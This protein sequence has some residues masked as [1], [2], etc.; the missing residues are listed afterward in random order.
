MIKKIILIVVTYFIACTFSA[1]CIKLDHTLSYTQETAPS[2]VNDMMNIVTNFLN[3]EL[4]GVLRVDM[5]YSGDH[6]HGMVGNQTIKTDVKRRI[7]NSYEVGCY[8]ITFE[9]L[10]IDECTYQGH[11][12]HLRHNCVPPANCRNTFGSYECDCPPNFFGMDKSGEITEAMY[13]TATGGLTTTQIVK[14]GRCGGH[15][16]TETCCREE[17]LH[18]GKVSCSRKCKGD[19]KCINDPCITLHCGENAVCK[20]LGGSKATCEC[21][22]GYYGDPFVACQ[23]SQKINYCNIANCPCDCYCKH[24]EQLGG[25]V[26]L[27]KNGY[28][29]VDNSILGKPVPHDHISKGGKRLDSTTCLDTSLPELYLN[30]PNPYIL[31]QGDTYQEYGIT[32]VDKNNEDFPR[33]IDFEYSKPFGEYMTEIGREQVTYTLKTPWLP[34]PE[35]TII[36]DVIVIDVD[37]CTYTGPIDQ[38]RHKC[39]PDIANCINTEGSYSC[40]CKP[41]YI[42]DGYINGSGCLDSVPPVITCVGQ[43]CEPLRFQVCDS[44]GLLSSTGR[45]L[46]LDDSLSYNFIDAEL[47]KTG[48]FCLPHEYPCFHAFDETAYGTVDLTSR[49][50]QGPF[51]LFSQDSNIWIF[52]VPFNVIDD[53]GNYAEPVFR[54]IE[55][56]KVDIELGK[57]WV[58]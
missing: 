43:G 25:Y 41:G 14:G 16:S 49:I 24:E 22:P 31:R 5:N 38:F 7:G 48:N 45:V 34:E 1:P 50:Q 57:Q 53:D 56:I 4:R 2:D 28:I 37:E 11:V 42:G 54:Y 3:R 26:C 58:S 29:S 10:D 32:V 20:R 33:Q 55:V 51:E 18:C 39:V 27:P 15:S 47:R 8:E 44:K 17:D 52:R 23:L 9:I 35:F 21:Q 19:F 40:R 30:P 12:Q 13:V 6:I 46:V 36:R